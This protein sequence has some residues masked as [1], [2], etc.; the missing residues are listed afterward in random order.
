MQ[1]LLEIM[2]ALHRIS[3]GNYEVKYLAWKKLELIV[4]EILPP[5][6]QPLGFLPLFSHLCDTNHYPGFH[7]YMQCNSLSIERN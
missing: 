6:Q 3:S 4:T 2:L 1:T 7:P 5:S